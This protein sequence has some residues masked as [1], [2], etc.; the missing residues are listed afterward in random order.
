M[1]KMKLIYFTVILTV[2]NRAKLIFIM[3]IGKENLLH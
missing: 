3:N 2:S 1:T